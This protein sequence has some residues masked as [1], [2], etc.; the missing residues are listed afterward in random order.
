MG[1]KHQYSPPES[2]AKSIAGL[3]RWPLLLVAFA[4]TSCTRDTPI[5]ESQYRTK[6]VG[7]WQGT[8]G[9]MKETIS[10]RADG[11]FTAQVR[12]RGFIS[13]TLS[14]GVTGT[15]GGTWA[16]Q[17]NVI[18]LTISSAENERLLNKTA[19]STIESFKQN[20]LVV[21]SASGET[22]TFVREL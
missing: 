13:N 18:T 17:G 12:P 4:A 11:G 3:L 22:S 6:L 2:T 19:T 21:K 20:E 5:A 14:Q 10:Y 15:I 16:V 8:V 7:G 1:D 9:D